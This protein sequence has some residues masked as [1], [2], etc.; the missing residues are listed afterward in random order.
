M[1]KQIAPVAVAFAVIGAFSLA[2]QAQDVKPDR[3]IKY[4]QGIMGGQGWHMGVLAAMAKGDR[5]YDKDLAVRSATY[6]DQLI[7]MPWDGFPPGSDQ[8]APTKA[9]PE[10]WKEPAKFKQRQE[11]VMAETPKLVAAAKSGDLAQLKGAIG[12]VGNACNACHDDFRS[13]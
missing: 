4:R 3:A 2:V 1:K 13:K 9:K 7:H 6:V 12:P 5:P 8:G 11:A 10:I